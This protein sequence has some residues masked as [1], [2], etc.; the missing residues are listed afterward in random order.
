MSTELT[1]GPEKKDTKNWF[2]PN[3]FLERTVKALVTIKWRI[4]E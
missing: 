1:A 3:L 4:Q 2:N